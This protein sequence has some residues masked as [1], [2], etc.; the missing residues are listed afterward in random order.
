MLDYPLKIF[1]KAI[2]NESALVEDFGVDT[3]AKNSLFYID[4][5]G[6]MLSIYTHLF[7]YTPR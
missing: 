5:S 2:I 3:S 4:L 1:R 6:D 7:I